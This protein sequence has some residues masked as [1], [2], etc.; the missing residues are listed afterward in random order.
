MMMLVCHTIIACVSFLLFWG[1]L[2]IKV[3]KSIPRPSLS[4]NRRVN[5]PE[6]FHFW[7]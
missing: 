3:D 6:D 4:G 5:P 1:T 2:N 7:N